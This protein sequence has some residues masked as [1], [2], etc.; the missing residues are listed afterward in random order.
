MYICQFTGF[1][2]LEVCSFIVRSRA[3]ADVELDAAVEEDAIL[4]D[5]GNVIA[6]CYTAFCNVDG[7][8]R[9]AARGR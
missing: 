7:V 2:D 3:K 5:D 4:W 6:K 1:L 8:E 9:D